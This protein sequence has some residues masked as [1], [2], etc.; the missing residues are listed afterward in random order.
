MSR[1][2][3]CPLHGPHRRRLSVRLPP[4]A[5]GKTCSREPVG[6]SQKRQEGL[7]DQGSREKLPLAGRTPARF[8]IRDGP[9]KSPQRDTVAK[10]T[11]KM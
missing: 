10:W 11:E 9:Q 8:G 3:K 6:E 1:R 2:A 4:S 5:A 7:M